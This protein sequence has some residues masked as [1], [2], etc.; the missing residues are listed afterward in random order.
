MAMQNQ[1]FPLALLVY[2]INM[3]LCYFYDTISYVV[4]ETKDKVKS[5]FSCHSHLIYVMK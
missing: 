2:S 5:C 1:L 3:T 4:I